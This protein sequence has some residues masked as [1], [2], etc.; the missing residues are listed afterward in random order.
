VTG[1]AAAVLCGL[2]ACLPR[3]VVDNAQLA[4][5]LDTTDEWIRARTGIARRRVADPGIATSDLAVEAG[6]RAVK[7][8]AVAGVRLGDVDAV[9][10]ATAT[11]DRPLPATAPEVAT[12]LGLTDVPAFDLAAVCGGF[13]YSLAVAAG[14]IGTGVANTVLVIGADT[15]SGIL[16]PHDRTTRAIFGDGAGA[17]VLRRGSADDPGAVGPFDLGSDG[18]HAETVL[19]RG[20][21]SRQRATGGPAAEGDRYLS[22]QGRPVFGHAVRRMSASSR[23]VLG[24]A[25]WRVDQV[26]R[27]VAH[28]AN[29]RILTAVAEELGI[30]GSRVVSNIDRV[31]NTAAASIPIALADAAAEGALRPGH[32]VLLTSFGAGFAWGS[33]VLRWPRL[34]PDRTYQDSDDHVGTAADANRHHEEPDS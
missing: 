32:R 2:G 33:A 26:D 31:G 30:A 12:R 25:G 17:V 11:P 14:L 10:L 7:S 23:A 8:A 6:G 21:G 29:Q 16:D 34:T 27:L 19:I 4:R 1:A 13:V 22:M 18:G 28:Q 5:E 3:R 9:I 20:G 15:Y 24:R